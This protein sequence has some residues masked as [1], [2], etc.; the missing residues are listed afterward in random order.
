M[1]QHTP[2]PDPGTQ[3]QEL[4]GARRSVSLRKRRSKT[5]GGSFQGT[6]EF[7]TGDSKNSAGS[8]GYHDVTPMDDDQAAVIYRKLVNR[9]VW[10]VGPFGLSVP[11][12]DSR[13]PLSP[14]GQC[15]L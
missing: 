11:V 4:P 2:V 5:G 7:G 15:S 13:R 1:S 12:W 10:D 14:Q 8:H 3:A 6:A 9:M